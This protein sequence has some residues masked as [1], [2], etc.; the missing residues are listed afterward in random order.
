V[1]AA[2]VN[3]SV[4]LAEAAEVT[5]TL[6]PTPLHHLAFTVPPSDTEE[7]EPISP[8]VEVAIVDAEE[9]PVP[10]AGVEIEMALIDEHGHD[11]DD[12]GGTITVLT[13]ANGVAVFPD[14]RVDGEDEEYRLRASAPGL[15]ELG[16]VLS[17]PFDVED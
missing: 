11:H 15:P 9:N 13:G 7:D 3:G 12:L 14:L 4:A 6:V 17:A 1:V 8:A 16:S 2:V 10:V 5:V